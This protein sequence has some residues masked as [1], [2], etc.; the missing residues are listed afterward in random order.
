[1]S[2]QSDLLIGKCQLSTC[3]AV[4]NFGN[5]YK[6][7]GII[8]FLRVNLNRANCV[9]KV[10]LALATKINSHALTDAKKDTSYHYLLII[11]CHVGKC[12]VI[13]TVS[14]VQGKYPA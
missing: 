7:K 10:T 5:S 2:S 1:V 3:V 11:E 13:T 12:T 8:G 4:K 14:N 9:D 6:G